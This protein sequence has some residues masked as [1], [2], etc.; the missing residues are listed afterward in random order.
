LRE[1]RPPTALRGRQGRSSRRVR[2]AGRPPRQV[3][4]GQARVE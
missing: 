1:E 2:W 3:G 4:Q